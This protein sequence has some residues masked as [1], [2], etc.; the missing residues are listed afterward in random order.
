[1]FNQLD[2]KRVS[3]NDFTTKV[4]AFGGSSIADMYFYLEPLLKK[5]PEYVIL[6]VGTN[7]CVSE[8]GNT[9]F[10]NLLGLKKHIEEKVPG[11]KVIISQPTIRFDNNLVSM[12]VREV[13]KK[14][15]SSKIPL[16][17]NDNIEIRHIGKK[18]LHFNGY[19]TGRCAMNILSLI[20]QL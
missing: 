17:V 19:G 5:E 8:S 20:K 13:V 14:L 15:E 11:V 1:M 6:H 7:D 3:K 12:R 2:E 10:Q 18:G 4:R 16:L 9:V